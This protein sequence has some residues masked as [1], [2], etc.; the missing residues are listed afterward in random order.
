MTQDSPRRLYTKDKQVVTTITSATCRRLDE[1]A[2]QQLMSRADTI[3][4]FI[5]DGLN[6]AAQAPP[7]G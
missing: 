6:R 1:Y 5:V 2:E 7:S 4:V 3:R